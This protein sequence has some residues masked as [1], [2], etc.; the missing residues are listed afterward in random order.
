MAL[1][2]VTVVGMVLTKIRGLLFQ[3]TPRTTVKNTTVTPS[4]FGQLLTSHPTYKRQ[5]IDAR[6]RSIVYPARFSADD[7][8]T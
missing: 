1:V 6:R 5:K 7:L 4:R 8:G 2:V 3:K